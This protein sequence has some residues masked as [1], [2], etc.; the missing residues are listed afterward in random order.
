MTQRRLR[1]TG[2]EPDIGANH[3]LAG[4]R[5]PGARSGVSPQCFLYACYRK[6]TVNL[7][8]AKNYTCDTA[9]LICTFNGECTTNL[10]CVQ[11]S[12]DVTAVCAKATNTCKKPCTI[13]Q[14]CG[15]SGVAGTR[16][17]N[18][19]CGADGYCADIT[20]QCATD[21]DCAA[22]AANGQLVKKFCVAPTAAASVTYASA[23]TATK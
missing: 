16:F 19:V 1:G 21:N 9:K 8:C 18:L 14:D 15:P 5:R 4:I 3:P 6:C 13:D 10:D 17:K 2:D 11:K 7:D 22:T 20:G 12:G 23:I